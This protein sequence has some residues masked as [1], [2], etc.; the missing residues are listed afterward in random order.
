MTHKDGFFS[1]YDDDSLFL[2]ELDQ[3]FAEGKAVAFAEPED[4]SLLSIDEV[5][6][7]FLVHNQVRTEADAR[8]YVY[9]QR[10][11][12]RSMGISDNTKLDLSSVK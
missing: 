1:S 4:L 8:K 2:L 6:V 7:D 3:A 11:L 5:A 9:S 10:E 12:M